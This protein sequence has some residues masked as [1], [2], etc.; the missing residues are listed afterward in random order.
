MLGHAYITASIG[1]GLVACLLASAAPDAR[2][3]DAAFCV[4][5]KGPDQ[6]YRCR[7]NG[8]LGSRSDALKLYCVVR[9]AKEGG[10]ASCS[11]RDDIAGCNGTEKTYSYDLP[12]I[13]SGLAENPRV[14]KLRDQMARENKK[15]RQDDEPSKSLVGIS[16]RGIRNLRASLGREDEKERSSPPQ[17]SSLPQQDPLPELPTQ[18]PAP[19]PL[20]TA[21]DPS[22]Q[23]ADLPPGSAAPPPKRRN[24]VGRGAQNVGSFTRK[25]YRC[26]RSLFRNCGSE[27]E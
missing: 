3:E 18:T 26:V 17:S 25:T 11:A 24:R 9:T 19:L 21:P 10:H 2:A 14:K 12:N 6:T 13:P 16:R 20:S 27:A 8:D 22:V 23:S 15:F 7:V 5:C 1:T 4:V